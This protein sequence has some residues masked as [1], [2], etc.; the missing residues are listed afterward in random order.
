VNGRRDVTANVPRSALNV[1]GLIHSQVAP[2][3]P[4]GVW[5]KAITAMTGGWPANVTRPPIFGVQF[6][7]SSSPQKISH[8]EY[9]KQ[10]CG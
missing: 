8:D 1:F 3:V 5:V 4:S 10:I 7:R 9:G 2:A 6:I